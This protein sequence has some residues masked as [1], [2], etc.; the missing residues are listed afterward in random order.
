MG[1]EEMGKGELQHILGGFE[2]SSLNAA[3]D[4]CYACKPGCLTGCVSGNKCGTA[5]T[6]GDK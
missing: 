5:C 2:E 4:E 6:P 1:N 3:D